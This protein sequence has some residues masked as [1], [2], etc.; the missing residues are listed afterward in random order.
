MAADCIRHAYLCLLWAGRIQSAATPQE[1]S[2]VLPTLRV[3]Y[4]VMLRIFL[5]ALF[6]VSTVHAVTIPHAEVFIAMPEDFKPE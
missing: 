2:L 4:A 1:P 3:F 6:L 5:S